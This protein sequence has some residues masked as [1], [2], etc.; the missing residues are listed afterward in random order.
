MVGTK[1]AWEE[2]MGKRWSKKWGV[3]SQ[4]KK[5]KGMVE[6]T[7]QKRCLLVGGKGGGGK[8][9]KIANQ[10]VWKIKQER[11]KTKVLNQKQE[12][13]DVKRNRLGITGNTEKQAENLSEG[14]AG[15]G[16]KK[17][18]SHGQRYSKRG[19]KNRTIK[20]ELEEPGRVASR[21]DD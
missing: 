16:K 3:P 2:L 17:K 14:S 20:K 4:R 15:Q 11:G 18:T 21:K 12:M 9:G 7:F 13:A 1:G 6:D 10:T 19:K 8:G 5:K